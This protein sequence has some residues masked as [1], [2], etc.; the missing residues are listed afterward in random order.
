MFI[1]KYFINYIVTSIPKQYFENLESVRLNLLDKLFIIL[2]SLN[3]SSYLISITLSKDSW[4]CVLNIFVYFFL[5]G[6][7]LKL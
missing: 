5:I 7:N 2:G 6:A 3:L 1:R 4:N